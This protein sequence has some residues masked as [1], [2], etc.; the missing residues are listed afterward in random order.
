ME[1]VIALDGGSLN[2]DFSNIIDNKKGILMTNNPNEKGWV[3]TNSIIQ[4]NG[5]DEFVYSIEPSISY[6]NTTT[7]LEGE[8]NISTDPKF[9]DHNKG[10]WRLKPFSECI[11]AGKITDVDYD[12]DGN[13]RPLPSGSNPDIRPLFLTSTSRRLMSFLTGKDIRRREVDVRNRGRIS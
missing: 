9:I 2:I 5:R 1:G 11:G 12:K 7:L 4:N 8:G 10:D 6:C 3:I 13:P